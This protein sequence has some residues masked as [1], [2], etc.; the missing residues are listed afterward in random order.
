MREGRHLLVWGYRAGIVFGESG[1]HIVR[2]V[3]IEMIGLA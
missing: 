3:S 2:D 1:V